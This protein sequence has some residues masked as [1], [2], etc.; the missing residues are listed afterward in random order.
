[1]RLLIDSCVSKFA[2]NDLRGVGYDLVWI[3]AEGTD[4][5]DTEILNRAHQ[6]NRI[7]VIWCLYFKSFTRPLYVW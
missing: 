6:E 4:P 2:V 3:P 1:M 5:G 7:S